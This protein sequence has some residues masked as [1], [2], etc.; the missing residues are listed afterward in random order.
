MDAASPTHTVE[1]FGRTCLIVSKT[2][3][4]AVTDPPG[5]FT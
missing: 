1:T 5:E 2:A 4:P 3:I